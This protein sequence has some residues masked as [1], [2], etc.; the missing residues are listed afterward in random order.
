MKTPYLDLPE[1]EATQDPAMLGVI[2]YL[3]G[4]LAQPNPALEGVGRTG[5]VCPFTGMALASNAIRFGRENVEVTDPK[6]RETLKRVLM[7]EHLGR[8]FSEVEATVAD[9]RFASL[10]VLADG[11]QSAD[12]C[13]QFVSTVQ[14][15]LQPDFVESRLLMSELHPHNKVPSLYSP[16]FFPSGAVPHPI[17]FIRRLIE[18]DIPFL[19]RSDRYPPQTVE[20]VRAALVEQF[21]EE[22]VESA[23]RK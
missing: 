5:N 20:R 4:F 19:A 16:S 18:R 21:G 13:E 3:K 8:F 9:K 17:F 6:S 14:K 11:P 2:H 12:D 7:E 15:E 22:T 10:L 1:A 23:L